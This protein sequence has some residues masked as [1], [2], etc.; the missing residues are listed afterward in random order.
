MCEICESSTT[1]NRCDVLM[2]ARKTIR[3]SSSRPVAQRFAWSLVRALRDRTSVCFENFDWM[4]SIRSELKVLGLNYKPINKDRTASSSVTAEIST[5]EW[6]NHC[7]WVQSI[8]DV[9]Q[10]WKERMLQEKVNFNEIM[11]YASNS[12][13]VEEVCQQFFDQQL[14]PPS[15][16]TQLKEDFLQQ[17]EKLNKILLQYSSSD[18]GSW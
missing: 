7:Q 9:L 16:V 17:Y 8:Q 2:A 15:K 1:S 10:Q 6:L 12:S 18:L 13:I 11:Y 4:H 14:L 5:Q 3:D